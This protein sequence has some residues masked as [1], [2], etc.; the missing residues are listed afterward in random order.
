MEQSLPPGM[1]IPFGPVPAVVHV[2]TT[3]PMIAAN[4]IR[5]IDIDVVI[6]VFG[7]EVILK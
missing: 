4:A 1:S 3:E 6:C 5:N 7:C 2:P